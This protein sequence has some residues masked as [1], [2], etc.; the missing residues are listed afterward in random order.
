MSVFRPHSNM[1]WSAKIC[2]Q[3]SWLYR[4]SPF[5]LYLRNVNVIYYEHVT[6]V[7]L[8][9]QAVWICLF[10]PSHK[11]AD[12]VNMCFLEF[13]ISVFLWFGELQGSGGQCRGERCK[14]EEEEMWSPEWHEQPCR[15]DPSGWLACWHSECW[16]H[17]L[18]QCRHPGGSIYKNPMELPLHKYYR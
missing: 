6:M 5:S 11:T 17:L 10:K 4:A 12:L 16:K 18:V 1:L 3:S 7:M 14:D 13:H 15:L 2:A 9:F 8:V